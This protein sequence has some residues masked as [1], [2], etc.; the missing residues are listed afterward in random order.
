MR[1]NNN[2]NEDRKK[3]YEEEL[4]DD[5]EGLVERD[6]CTFSFIRFAA[7][8]K[9]CTSLSQLTCMYEERAVEVGEYVEPQH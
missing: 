1:N 6:S 3:G 7:M 9:Q 5:D 4:Q 2:N 8:V